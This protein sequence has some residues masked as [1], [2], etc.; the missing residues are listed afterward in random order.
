MKNLKKKWQS[1]F[2]KKSGL[3]GFFKTYWPIFIALLVVFLFFWKVFVKNQI[4]LPADFVVGTYY[5]WLDYKW[6]YDVGVPVKNSITSDVVSVIYPL[7]M[8]AVDL[9][10][11]GKWPL[12]NPFMFFGYPLLANF[13]AA[14]LSPTIFLYLFLPKLT[15][16]TAQIIIQPVLGAIFSY[17]FLRHLKLSRWSSWIGGIIYAFSGF[18]MIWLEWNAHSL[19]A[20]FLPLVLLL[21]DKLLKKSNIKVGVLL[22]FIIALQIF[23]GY[24]QL[25]IYTFL[26]MGILILFR[27][28]QTR[29]ILFIGIFVFFGLLL[30]SIQTLPALELLA[31]SQR[32]TE[33]IVDDLAYLPWQNL[34]TF[35]APDYFGNHA[36]G[37]YWGE[38]NYTINAGY[39]GLIT[40]MLATIGLL[41][42]Q[43]KKE[44]K[45][46]LSVLIMSL[47]LAFQTPVSKLV[48][49]YGLLGSAAASN[50]RVLVL[51]NLSLAFLAAYGFEKLLNFKKEQKFRS[52]YFPFLVIFSVLIYSLMHNYVVGVRNLILPGVLLLCFWGLLILRKLF[53][54]IIV[55]K[56]VVTMIGGL[57]I[58]ELFRFGWK[59]TPFSP[60]KLVFPET[61]VISFLKKQPKPFRL[62]P[63]GVIPMN[64]WVPYDLESPGGYDAAYPD[65]VAKYIAVANSSNIEATKM[66]RYGTISNYQS[67]LFNLA[68]TKYFLFQKDKVDH[69]DLVKL[70]FKL[71]H[72]DKSV[73]VY[74]NGDV[75]PRAF[76]VYN[77]E[78]IEPGKRTLQELIAEDFPFESTVILEKDPGITKS[79]VNLVI[80]QVD[81]LN[82]GDQQSTLSIHS[83]TAGLLFISDL[84]YPGWK[85]FVDGEEKDILPAN[86]MYRAIVIPD[87]KH[88]IRFIY[89]PIS[90]KIGK[91][92]SL[93]TLL[94]LAGLVLYEQKNK[95]RKK[96]S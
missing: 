33:M 42:Y 68:N 32:K 38:G 67:P 14:V 13:Q 61:P 58:M 40:L 86:Y 88:L 37:N 6:G 89:D 30:S 48:L 90:F 15:A 73:A 77:W 43:K 87:G 27:S 75:L 2:R 95:K 23:S 35:F 54:N 28:L 17:F 66:G 93:A 74:E 16:W 5:P 91:G 78:I 60:R 34:I 59:Y 45:F 82:Y 53:K 41:A 7:R 63:E 19:V 50:T 51:S 96:S 56:M 22:S 57:V 18:N 84:N 76:M 12:W 8:Y 25:M 36:T 81:Y 11:Q 3:R 1:W 70:N 49:N 55:R 94:F 64:M 26:A 24:P 21:T 20:S 9:I 29:K 4:P 92:V 71:V 46:L 52:I 72:E 83:D 47:V 80:N 79:D 44:T 85:V 69:Q 62:F 39:A 65:K 31:N 10:K